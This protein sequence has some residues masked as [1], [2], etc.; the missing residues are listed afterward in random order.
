MK[1]KMADIAQA[2]GISTISVSR[3]LAG[4]EGVSDKLKKKVLLKASEM[5]YCRSRN[6]KDYKI[7]LLHQKPFVQDNSNYSSMIQGME[8]E[9]QMAGFEYDMEFV[10]KATQAK[11]APP[12]KI[13][14]GSRYDGFIFIGHFNNTYIN[15]VTQGLRNCVLYTGYAPSAD[16]D[17]IWYSFSNS[18]YLQCKYLLDKGHRRIGYIGNSNGY[19]SKEKILGIVT[20]LEEHSLPVDQELFVYGKDTAE[21]QM[22]ELIQKGKGP[23]AIICQW[24]YTAIRLIQYLFEQDI[25]IPDDVS[26]VGYGNTE[27]SSFCIPALTTMGLHIDFACKTSVSLLRKRLD[28]PNK[29]AEH[30]LIDSSFIERNSVRPL[31]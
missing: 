22:V 16:C 7:L 9:L 20:A 26:V 28:E 18:G 13:T 1:T 27:M 25:H 17:S 29:P 11:S 30:I 23:T 8:K 5:G 3:A 14:R 31:K 15:L 24:D 19:A 2:L 4:Q 21:Q 6:Q 12:Q 10:D